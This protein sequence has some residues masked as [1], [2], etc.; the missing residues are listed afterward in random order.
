MRAL[1]AE[2]HDPKE[3]LNSNYPFFE[4]TREKLKDKPNVVVLNP[5]QLLKDMEILKK[6]MYFQNDDHLTAEGQ[7]AIAKFIIDQLHLKE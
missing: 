7:E 4:K 2:F 3:I 5:I 1:G 6:S